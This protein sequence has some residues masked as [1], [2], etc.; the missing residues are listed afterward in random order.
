MTNGNLSSDII[1]RPWIGQD[2][3]KHFYA[4]VFRLVWI[5]YLHPLSILTHTNDH[6][7][8]VPLSL[9]SFI[10]HA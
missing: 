9:H 7:P 4:K 8:C 6:D 10:L 5:L 1:N 2:G 3:Q